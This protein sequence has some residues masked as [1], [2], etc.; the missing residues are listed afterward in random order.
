M[1]P[2]KSSLGLWAALAATL[3]A[4][5]YAADMES[6]ESP[7]EALSVPERAARPLPTGVVPAPVVTGE[8]VAVAVELA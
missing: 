5:W 2:A 7:D 3:A 4:T 8:A 1:S 6:P